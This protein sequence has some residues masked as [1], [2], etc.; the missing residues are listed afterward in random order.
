M[1]QLLRIRSLRA[2]PVVITVVVIVVVVAVAGTVVGRPFG[3]T[4]ISNMPKPKNVARR[5]R[6]HQKSADIWKLPMGLPNAS[7]PHTL[8][9]Y[10]P[11]PPSIRLVLI[12]T[13]YF[14]SYPVCL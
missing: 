12:L 13:D 10:A 4:V 7:S 8:T 11:L 14:P 1:K 3:R 5:P 9:L 2:G 6:R